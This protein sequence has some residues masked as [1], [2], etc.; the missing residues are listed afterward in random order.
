MSTHELLI[1]GILRA[2]SLA[3]LAGGASLVIALVYRW[4]AGDSVPE[5]VAVLLGLTVVALILNTER[6]LRQVLEGNGA[7]D[8]WQASRTI[9]TLA[10]SSIGADLGRRIGDQTADRAFRGTGHHFNREFAQVVRAAG[11]VVTVTIPESIGDVDGFDPVAEET[12]TALAGTTLVFPRRVTVGEL[13]ARLTQRLETDYGIGRV[14]VEVTADG[15]VTHLA[16]GAREAGLGPTL[17]PGTTAV[18]IQADPAFSA[19]AG[20]LVQVWRPG[21][22]GEPER[23]CTGELRA[24]AAD[25]VT[26]AVEETDVAALADDVAYRLVT[27][28]VDQRADREF[29]GLLRAATETMGVIAVDADSPL[30]G[31][32]VGGLDVT[33]AA[34]RDE[35]GSVT[36]IPSRDTAI[37]AGSTLYVVARPDA[38][39]AFERVDIANERREDVPEPA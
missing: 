27:L 16:V 2:L 12:K 31:V 17:A 24:T 38:L 25:V 8:T 34:I 39:R 19:S 35:N 11:R 15:E 29:A 9:G 23:V 3:A 30:T 18:A 26:V 37:T 21:D 7:F 4:Y 36:P 6:T 1:Y 13:A 14:D 5:G 28:P 22:D 20:D 10:L 33:V 32:P